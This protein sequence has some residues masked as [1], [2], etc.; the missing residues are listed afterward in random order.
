MARPRRRCDWRR[1]MKY[2]PH[3]RPASRL[4]TVRTTRRVWA[5]LTKTPCADYSALAQQLGLSK[6]TVFRAAQALRDAGYLTFGHG[7]VNARQ[8]LVPFVV[9]KKA[10]Q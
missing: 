5:A 10:K 3:T 7:D 6:S 8:I 1:E 9:S 2:R 4:R